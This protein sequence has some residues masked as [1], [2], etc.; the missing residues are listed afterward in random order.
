VRRIIER[1]LLA[2]IL[3]AMT[4]FVLLVL[5]G[6]W[7]RYEKQA[8]ASGF[9]EA[10]GRYLAPQAVSPSDADT[11]SGPMTEHTP[12]VAVA[13][14]R[15]GPAQVVRQESKPTGTQLFEGTNQ[16]MS[17]A[18]SADGS[19]AI[20]GGPGHHNA[21]LGRS[22]LVGPAGA[23]WVFTRSHGVWTQQ[24]N[25]LVGATSEYGGGLW[26]QGASVALSAD[27]NTAIVGGPSDNKTM[28]AAWVFTR[29]GGAWTQQGDKLVGTD[30]YRMGEAQSPRGQGMAVAL[31]ADGNTA[32]VGGW[33]V[34]AAWVFTRNGSGVWT[35]AGKLV[36]DGA[37][38]R[39]HRGMSVALSADGNTA[40]VG[41][42]SDNSKTGAAWVFSRSRGLWT[43]Q[44]KKLVGTGAVGSAN[45]G[46]SVALS[47][48]GN[49]AILGGPSDNLWDPSVPFGLGAAGAA[50]VFSRSGSGWTQEGE[51]LVS[52]RSARQGTSV[53]LSADG[54]IAIVGALV[55]DGAGGGGLVFTRNGG[56]WTLDKKLVSTSAVGKSA[57][58]VGLSAD[59]SVVMVGGSNDNGGIGAVWVFA[60]SGGGWSQD[61]KLIATDSMGKSTPS[62]ALSAD[63]SR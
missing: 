5:I 35:Q 6:L 49:T 62:V 41:G 30:A 32:L 50:W 24:D 55:E 20:V 47:A 52:T 57:P 43:Q 11:R 17:I 40:L 19:T 7:D 42:W 54:N 44:G 13:R 8:A 51:K 29:T 21:D 1:V 56:Q 38:G 22:P 33:G 18:L 48:D 39:A 58:S 28:G 14:D 61:K 37:V 53:A 63:D 27:G 26:S 23:A 25:K 4:G 36:G 34:E 60:R 45:Q 3:F 16:G 10:D 59:G 9:N 46:W 31:S 12:H 2:T 15:L